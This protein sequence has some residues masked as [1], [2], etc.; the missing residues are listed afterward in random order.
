MLLL[1]FYENRFSKNETIT[2]YELL[3][4]LSDLKE[5]VENDYET[6]KNRAK[7]INFTLGIFD[8]AKILLETKQEREFKKLKN[9]TRKSIEHN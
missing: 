2:S 3:N 1:K 5:L 4:K 8:M 9:E 6:F 7:E